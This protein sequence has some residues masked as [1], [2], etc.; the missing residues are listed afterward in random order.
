MTNTGRRP[1]GPGYH[2]RR[3]NDSDHG[4]PCLVYQALDGAYNV[5]GIDDE[6]AHRLDDMPGDFIPLAKPVAAPEPDWSAA[7]EWATHHVF[8]GDAEGMWIKTDGTPTVD[9]YGWS[10][11]AREGWTDWLSSG[12]TL[13]LG[14]DWRTTLTKRP[15]A[16][17]ELLT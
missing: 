16:D 4:E 6:R 11:N 5:K 13:P 2:W 14:I 10:F 9:G 3:I 1:D 12:E 8:C 7:P 15:E 17:N